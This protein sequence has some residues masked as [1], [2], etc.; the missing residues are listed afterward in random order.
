M[1]K[2]V[3]G[4]IEKVKIKG[5]TT[6]EILAKIDTGAQH[7]SISMKLASE[8]ELGPVIKTAIIKNVHGKAVRPVVKATIEIKGKVIE[9]EFNLSN[10]E[11]M[12]YPLL[13]GMSVLKNGFL[14]DCSISENGEE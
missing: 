4:V 13:I 2:I 3:I 11:N 12:K 14:I 7:N 6:I 1:D 5:K 8:L 10:R 9:S